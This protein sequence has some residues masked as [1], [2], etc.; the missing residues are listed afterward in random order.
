VNK[1]STYFLLPPLLTRS[2][3]ARQAIRL[4]NQLI[5]QTASNCPK[6][7]QLGPALKTIHSISAVIFLVSLRI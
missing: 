2:A 4:R 1:C 7:S 5:K 3:S 6:D